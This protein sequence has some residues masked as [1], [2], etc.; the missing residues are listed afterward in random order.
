MIESEFAAW[1][2]T[3]TPLKPG[4]RELQLIISIRAPGSDGILADQQ[5]PDQVIE[6]RVRRGF[7]R[8]MLTMLKWIFVASLGAILATSGPQIFNPLIDAALKLFAAK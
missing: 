6:V 4:R 7:G 2:W 3:V 5:L 8:M 1:R